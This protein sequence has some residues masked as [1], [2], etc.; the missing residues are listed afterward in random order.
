V[1]LI[2]SNKR[3][4]PARQSKT[5]RF[6]G[7]LLDNGIKV[8]NEYFLK[9]LRPIIKIQLKTQKMIPLSKEKKSRQDILQY[10]FTTARS[11]H[12]ELLYW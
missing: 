10:F 2:G 1:P 11:V 12:F 7:F 4:L 6:A 3:H 8:T 9:V 5:P